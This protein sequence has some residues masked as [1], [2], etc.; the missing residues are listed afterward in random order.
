MKADV[1]GRSER[2]DPGRVDV[3]EGANADRLH[4]STFQEAERNQAKVSQSALH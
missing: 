1:R 4:S 3:E 2:V